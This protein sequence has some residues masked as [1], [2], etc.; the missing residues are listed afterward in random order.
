[1]PEKQQ[2]DINAIQIIN[3]IGITNFKFS[4]PYSIANAYIKDENIVMDVQAPT[5]ISNIKYII[6]PV[7]D[8]EFAVPVVVVVV[9]PKFQFQY[10]LIFPD[11]HLPNTPQ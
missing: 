10:D 6:F 2:H 4:L 7:L 3:P 8:V 1:L 11:I 5:N 9:R